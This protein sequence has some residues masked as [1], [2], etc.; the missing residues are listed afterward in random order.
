MTTGTWLWRFLVH[1]HG[2]GI[3]KKNGQQEDH[4]DKKTLDLF[5]SMLIPFNSNQFNMLTLTASIVHTSV[6][7]L[8]LV[9]KQQHSY[10]T[11]YK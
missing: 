5:V 10:K 8:Y 9:Y 4:S 1:N 11:M 6:R 7:I 2:V 3:L